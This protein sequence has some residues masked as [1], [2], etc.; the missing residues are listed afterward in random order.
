[1]MRLSLL[2]RLSICGKFD[3][4]LIMMPYFRLIVKF[5]FV[6]TDF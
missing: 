1:M 3:N 4:L 6:I 5:I 2:T